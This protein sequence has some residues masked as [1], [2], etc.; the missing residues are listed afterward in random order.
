MIYKRLHNKKRQ[1]TKISVTGVCVCMCV[2]VCTYTHI[3]MHI[4]TCVS[5]YVYMYGAQKL[6]SDV[7]LRCSSFHFFLE[8]ESFR[9]SSVQLL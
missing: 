6:T 7:F 4:F 3:H 2:C 8:A 9:I 5:T 1:K